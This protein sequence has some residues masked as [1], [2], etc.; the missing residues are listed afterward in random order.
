M[1][2][3]LFILQVIPSLFELI[4]YLIFALHGEKLQK[5]RNVF[6]SNLFI[7]FWR[8]NWT[9]LKYITKDISGRRLWRPKSKASTIF[10]TFKEYFFT[11]VSASLQ[12]HL[13]GTPSVDIVSE[14]DANQN[15]LLNVYIDKSFKDFCLFSSKSNLH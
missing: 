5:Q 14:R 15:H 2:R 10:N 3:N 1:K 8:Q 7:S 9:Y 13:A 12:H 6:A 4:I 11:Y